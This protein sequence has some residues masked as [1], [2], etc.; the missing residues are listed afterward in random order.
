MGFYIY[1]KAVSDLFDNIL[2][3]NKIKARHFV[4]FK[5]V[6]YRKRAYKP[7]IDTFLIKKRNLITLSSAKKF[8]KQSVF[9]FKIIR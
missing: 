8:F 5:L 4:I 6:Y 1:R 3:C 7:V 2:F 9:A